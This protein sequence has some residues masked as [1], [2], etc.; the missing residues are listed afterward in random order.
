MKKILVLSMLLLSILLQSCYS[1]PTVMLATSIYDTTTEIKDIDFVFDKIVESFENEDKELLKSL[2][3]VSVQN[4]SETLDSN[5]DE[6]FAVLEG[7][8]EVIEDK[9]FSP[10][11]MSTGE[12]VYEASYGGEDKFVISANGIRYT[13]FFDITT[14][15][16]FDSEDV[17]ITT[18][19]VVTD[20]AL[21][22]E[23]FER[24]IQ[25]GFYYQDIKETKEDVIWVE[26]RSYNYVK[27]TR[28][29]TTTD[30]LNFVNNEELKSTAVYNTTKAMEYKGEFGVLRETI[31]E[32]SFLHEDFHNYYYELSDGRILKC[33]V[34]DGRMIYEGKKYG[35]IIAL[36]IAD[37]DGIVE[38]IWTDD[39]IMYIDNGY[40]IVKEKD[41]SLTE[42][43]FL[44][45]IEKTSYM[46][47][48]V[49]T[50]GY[51]DAMR[52]Y[53]NYYK[54]ADGRYICVDYFTN[55]IKALSV[56]VD[57]DFETIWTN[58]DYSK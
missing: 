1:T 31:G 18:M 22:S 57:D 39:D 14:L 10:S 8:I 37:R 41:R 48:V 54:L 46:S 51:P 49:K 53:Y 33:Q 21:N 3:S 23:N 15:N 9:S 24:N 4:H 34:A 13:I 5:I 47:G 12:N 19:D 6:F 16:R 56:G 30:F 38:T 45:L 50:I 11:Y 55:E 26:E 2:F 20:D 42:K 58:E 28:G 36:Y 43:D 27:D 7:P 52:D 40:C 32:P 25:T 44:K 17:G 29:L 35:E